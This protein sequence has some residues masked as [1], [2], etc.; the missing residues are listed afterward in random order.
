[1]STIENEAQAT[2]KPAHHRLGPL[3][4]ALDWRLNRLQEDY[5][6][7]SSLARAELAKLRRGLGK[8]AGSVP[9]IWDSTIAAVPASLRGEDGF[10]DLEPSIAEQAAHSALTLFAAHQQSMPVRAHV[11]E[12]SF[13]RA[14]GMLARSEGRSAEAVTRRFMAVA[15]AQ[16]ID[17]VLAHIRGLVTQL[18]TAKLGFDYARLADDITGLLTPARAQQV[19]LAW[20]REFYRTPQPSDSEPEPAQQ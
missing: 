1:M 16:S 12:V 20:G 14:V 13:G 2:L 3:G 10:D 19:R 11:A 6:R 18:R 4:Q 15:T 7:R 9:E 8:S 17:E 5:L